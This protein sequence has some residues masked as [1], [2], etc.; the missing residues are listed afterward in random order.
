MEKIHALTLLKK[1]LIG[2]T[3]YWDGIVDQACAQNAWFTKENVERSLKAIQLEFLDE[4]KLQEWISAYDFTNISPKRVGIIMAGN[5]PLVGFADWLAVFMSGH[6]S[7]VKC[8]DK[9]NVL[10]PALMAKLNEIAP[11]YCDQTQIIERL[12][13]YDAT[14]AT[15]SNNS[16]IYF[17]SYF[18]HV[19]HIIR[20]NRT[21][22]AVI[23]A[24]TSDEVIEKIGRDIHTYFGLGCRNV[25][26]VYLPEGYDVTKLLAVWEKQDEN[27]NFNKYKNNFDYNLSLYLLNKIPFHTD[28]SV[29][30]VEDKS[31]FSR[32]SCIHYEIYKDEA[33]LLENLKN[34]LE[35]IQCIV[36]ENS[37]ADLSV[38]APGKTQEPGLKDYADNVDTM[39]FLATLTN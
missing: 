2:E 7:L 39:K 14:I 34:N 10:F 13:D 11:E 12:K 16:A 28:N 17:Q 37:L 31:L 36:S 3:E 9:D 25:S 29:I 22:V 33:E 30:L 20:K 6:I 21:S 19:P 18:N 27:I 24:D 38:I 26:K 4:V 32:I 35:D 23:N 15:G 5:L 8:S 1:S